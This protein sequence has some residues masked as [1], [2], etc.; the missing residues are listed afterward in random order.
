[1]KQ[2]ILNIL[3]ELIIQNQ[4]LKVR[5]I[6]LTTLKKI[7]QKSLDVNEIFFNSKIVQQ[8][9]GH[10]AGPACSTTMQIF[11]KTLI[12]NKFKTKIHHVAEGSMRFTVYLEGAGEL[13]NLAN[14]N[15]NKNDDLFNFFEEEG[16][17]EN[18]F[19]KNYYNL[20]KDNLSFKKKARIFYNYNNWEKADNTDFYAK[21]N[22]G[23]GERVGN[24]IAFGFEEWLFNPILLKLKIG[25]LECYRQNYFNDKV[26]IILFTRDRNRGWLSVAELKG[27][28]QIKDNEINHFKSELEKNNWQQQCHKD[29]EVICGNNETNKK[30]AKELWGNHW[31]SKA[32]ICTK[33]NP[34][35][36][37]LVNIKYEAIIYH[38][39]NE[40]NP[41]N[42]WHL[43]IRYNIDNNNLINEVNAN[44]KIPKNNLP[45]KNFVSQNERKNNLSQGAD[46]IRVLQQIFLENS[47]NEFVDIRAGALHRRVGG[48]PG[49]NHRMP[50]CCKVMQN[51]R[52]GADEIIASPP[53]GQGASLT[54]RYYLPR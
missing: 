14:D 23:Y 43:S 38:K 4:H 32:I 16:K 10:N 54:I 26:D 49:Y 31:N 41:N 25:F 13:N 35:D 8:F 45:L 27:V 40:F 48:Y 6:F 30:R 36:G 28:E 20:A 19:N 44:S 7:V 1:M 37:F 34:R 15:L 21:N 22:D 50:I 2:K 17:Q 53:S 5:P 18:L 52:I 3:D 51:A 39:L 33:Y 24:D 12:K 46:F 9:A 42:C 11:E 47:G 29:L